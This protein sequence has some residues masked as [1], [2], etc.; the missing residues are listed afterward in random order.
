L[1]RRYR[2][3]DFLLTFLDRAD[4]DWVMHAPPL[5]GTRVTLVC[6]RWWCQAGTLFSPL[7]YKVLLSITN[8]YVHIWSVDIVQ[9]ILGSSC[10]VFELAPSSIAGTDLSSFMVVAL[11]MHLDII[12]TE[13]GCVVL[14]L[15]A[16][17]MVGQ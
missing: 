15:E 12:P 1:V 13:V 5:E 16:P 7:R 8:V 11:T 17:S 10:V 14:E 6:R 3:R 2:V 4:A 9:D